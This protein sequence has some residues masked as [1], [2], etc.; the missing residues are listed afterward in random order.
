MALWSKVRLKCAPPT[1]RTINPKKLRLK[2]PRRRCL[3]RRRHWL[4]RLAQA[5]S[6]VLRFSENS[7]HATAR[8]LF[9]LWS[10]DDSRT[11][12]RPPGQRPGRYTV[13]ILSS[14]LL[15]L[16]QATRSSCSSAYRLA[17]G[18][19]RRDVRGGHRIWSTALRFAPSHELR[20][21]VRRPHPSRGAEKSWA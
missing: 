5:A 18:R 12:V 17:W 20:R 15:S 16:N 9:Y 13:L 2:R 19:L 1:R 4:L 21:C 8:A 14:N 6:L 7:G 11:L 10:M 3:K